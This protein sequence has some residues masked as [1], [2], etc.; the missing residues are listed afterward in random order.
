MICRGVTAHN[1]MLPDRETLGWQL[2]DAMAQFSY[3]GGESTIPYEILMPSRV[4][5]NVATFGRRRPTSLKIK[6]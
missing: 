4:L 1:R 2:S 5:Y 3:G 6:K